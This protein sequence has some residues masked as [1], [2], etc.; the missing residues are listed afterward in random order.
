MHWANN[1]A[2]SNTPIIYQILK[3]PIEI[4]SAVVMPTEE[5]DNLIARK[6]LVAELAGSHVLFF[7]FFL[8]LFFFLY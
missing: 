7:F 4:I 6:I 8:T 3:V 2:F 1:V 5:R